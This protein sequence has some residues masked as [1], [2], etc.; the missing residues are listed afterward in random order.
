MGLSSPT[1]NSSPALQDRFPHQSLQELPARSSHPELNSFLGRRKTLR[2]L[3][4]RDIFSQIQG[5]RKK[6]RETALS[7]IRSYW[8]WS[9]LEACK[10]RGWRGICSSLL[11]WLCLRNLWA[12]HSS[13]EFFSAV[14]ITADFGWSKEWGVKS[15]AFHHSVTTHQV[16]TQSQLG[17]K[18]G[19]R[20]AWKY[21]WT[22]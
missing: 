16:L 13:W 4:K 7:L 12:F 9:S 10:R 15:I 1:C 14:S 20:P 3:R 21:S 19:P 2:H 5:P 11:P 17:S 6:A 22:F 8:S 18:L